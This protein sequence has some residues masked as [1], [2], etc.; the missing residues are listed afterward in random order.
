MS[1]QTP[2]HTISVLVGNKPGVLVRV[3]VVF[4]RRGYNIDSLVVSPV[5]DS[6][7]SRMTITCS[8]D[9]S[10][11]DQIIKQLLKLIDVVRA[12]D[13]TG[14][15]VI[16]KEMALIK[17]KCPPD[18]RTAIL[19]IA[20][21]FKGVTVDFGAESLILQIAGGSEKI[22]HVIGLVKP[23]G[24]VDLVRTGKILMARGADKT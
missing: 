24:I 14:E 10:T 20:E 2:S 23:F 12:I 7:F 5:L 6:E 16:E 4:A 18:S 8:G 1:T 3:A 22:D 15:S 19:Q 9:P 17:I 11:L 13:H 21:H